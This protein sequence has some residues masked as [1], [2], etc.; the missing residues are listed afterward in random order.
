MRSS[1]HAGRSVVVTAAPGAGLT[2]ALDLLA[3]EL[4]SVVVRGRESVADSA[5]VPFA[6]IIAAH[7]LGRH[8]TLRVYTD[9]P[10]AL[11]GRFTA[12]IVDDA[13]LLDTGSAVLVAQLHRAGLAVVL[14]SHDRAALHPSLRD[15]EGR[16][17]SEHLA[18]LDD[19]EVAELS[20]HLLG[21]P[22]TDPSLRGLLGRAR[23]LPAVV[24]DLLDRCREAD[25]L[26]HLPAGRHILQFAVG[27][28]SLVA[29]GID[30]GVVAEHRPLLD[31]IAVAESLPVDRL[32]PEAVGRVL[33]DGL[34]A[35]DG[36]VVTPAD[37]LLREYLVSA[38]SRRRRREV[39][40]EAAGVVAGHAAWGDLHEVLGAYAEGPHDP[41]APAAA[42]WLL[43]HERAV[44]AA[45]LIDPGGSRDSFPGLL[46]GADVAL[47]LGDP[48][49]ALDLLDRAAP[50]APDDDDLVTVTE[51]WTQVLRGSAADDDALAERL[52]G[53][54]PRFT[55]DDVRTS[56]AGAVAR[57]RT[58]LGRAC[59][60][61]DDPVRQ[62]LAESLGGPL[63]A[64]RR[65]AASL[66]AVRT[67]G[68]D[69][70]LE[71]HLGLL[72]HFLGIVYDG[73]L[74]LGRAIAEEQYALAERAASP[75]LGLWA[76]NRAKIAFHAGQY[77]DAVAIGR[78]MRR[79]LAWR[80]DLAL[81]A[82]GEALLASA[83]AR[84]DRPA[85]AQAIVA[86]LSTDDRRLPRVGIGVARV[87]A[88]TLIGAGDPA[89]AAALLAAAGERAV[90]AG[91]A[92]S[93]ALALDEAFVLHPTAGA[94]ERIDALT[95]SSQLVDTLA[96]RARAVLDSD[97]ELLVTVARR[98]EG[99]I[100]AGRSAQAWRQA[101]AVYTRNG[102]LDRAERAEREGSAVLGRWQAVAWPTPPSA[103][104]E[105]TSREWEV[106]RRAARRQR[107]REIAD[108]LGLSVR[109][110]DN[111]L[112]RV[113][114]KL[115]VT[116][117]EDLAAAL[118]D[119]SGG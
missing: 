38:L 73:Q 62:A 61:D 3:S 5:L 40:R 91:E 78:V 74:E 34:L 103:P 1:A 112:A 98:F 85:E 41:S 68:V 30:P 110:V 72:A 35:V 26:R 15:L 27:P 95:G 92:H 107:S 50:L 12:V 22:L 44:E 108:E 116:R 65:R 23:G 19:D 39:A 31:L 11:A 114:R 4:A 79:H 45:D 42:R 100:Q 111:H 53:V 14:G 56:V 55:Q 104:D 24:V 80:D 81:H 32:D 115:G 118:A 75:V 28:R 17:D 57:R 8:E 37:P 117:R 10:R 106:A 52:E 9:L 13:E 101:A 109:T 82:P 51:R 76:Y 47:A 88:E 90:A 46:I 102:D 84:L 94:A 63:E 18:S 7:D 93:G 6:G 36:G 66:R 77:V 48:V 86:G 29:V 87:E 58:V 33:A 105:L 59:A 69:R 83:L 67:P 113:F 60:P 21:G 97:A 16:F 25:L 119:G 70:T 43:S 89:A 2:A 71:E 96:A 54:L 20:A 99:M 64:A 49:H